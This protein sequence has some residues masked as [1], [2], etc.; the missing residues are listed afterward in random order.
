MANKAKAHQGSVPLLG[1]RITCSYIREFSPPTLSH[2]LLIVGLPGIG[3]VSK[4]TA[5]NLVVTLKAR[6]IATLYSPH[7]PNQVLSMPSGK[8][9]PF[10][11]HLYHAKAGTGK[12]KRDLVIA[13][14]DLQPLTI[15]GQYEVGSTILEYFGNAG[16]RTVISMAGYATNRKTDKP[17]LFVSAT[18]PKLLAKLV[19]CGA[20]TSEGAVPIVGMAGLM[21]ALAPLF[22][23][24]GACVLVETP[25]ATVDAVGAGHLTNLLSRFSGIK[26]DTAGLAARAKKAMNVIEQFEKQAQG[27]ESGS[28][29]SGTAPVAPEILKKDTL[30]YI[31]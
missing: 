9:R 31:R 23:A 1:K 28:A 17:R 21:P 26:M 14:G 2:P 3:L 5:D 12:H 6:K 13:K 10:G 18:H 27:A 11:L 7:F 8:L 25:G 16:G 20:K 19:K 24:H 30:N 22:G 29:V 15:E 4:L